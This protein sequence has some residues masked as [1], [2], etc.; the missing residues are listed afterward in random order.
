MLLVNRNNLNMQ[1]C[2]VSRA[3][4]RA[5]LKRCDNYIGALLEHL[6]SVLC[7]QLVRDKIMLSVSLHLL[8]MVKHKVLL[9]KW[10]SCS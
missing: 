1:P 10:H 5:L 6:L 8:Y 3:G 9:D 7:S 4:V 2:Y